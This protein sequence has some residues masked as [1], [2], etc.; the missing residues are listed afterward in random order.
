VFAG[1]IDKGVTMTA[2]PVEA[3]EIS[4]AEESDDQQSL[5]ELVERF[6]RDS[7]VLVLREA[8]LAAARHEADVRRAGRD[9]TAAAIAAVAL[10]TAFLLA[11]WAAV[12]G[13]SG[14]LSSW[15]APLLLAAVWLVVGIA[16]AALPLARVRHLL[17]RP[18]PSIEQREQ[19]RDDAVQRVRESLEQLGAGLADEAQARMV[20]A[21]VP[22]A[23][24]MLETGE[25]VLEASEEL[26][27]DMVENA[28]GGSVVGQVI[29]FA[30]I[31]GR[32]GIRV[33]TT[34]L[35]GPSEEV[36]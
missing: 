11:N 12:R 8:E 15:R 2:E 17:S 32:Y 24:G 31:P 27:E 22:S 21:M 36:E 9:A 1:T 19:A 16:V 26:L 4:A 23:D 29:D 30:L 18:T 33:A 10:G 28:P 7:S 35:K 20:S 14:S 34:V 25:D 13:L 6:G 5:M 3:H